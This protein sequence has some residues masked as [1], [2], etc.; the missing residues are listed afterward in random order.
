VGQTNA[1]NRRAFQG[2]IEKK[3]KIRSAKGDSW[4]KNTTLW[5]AAFATLSSGLLRAQDIAVDWQGEAGRYRYVLHVT[6]PG[7]GGG[8]PTL[9]MIDQHLDWEGALPVTS[10]SLESSKLKFSTED[11]DAS[12][13]G[14]VSA[15]GTSIA[16]TWR[17]GPPQ[18]LQFVRAT[19]ETEWRDESPH[20]VQF[21]NV[22]HLVKLE[23]LDWGGSGRPLV[24]L[25]GL[26]NT[27][28]I[29]D[30]FAPK[31]TATYHVYGITRRGFGESS[32]PR[33]GYMADRL[34]DDCAGGH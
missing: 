23:V 9:T 12:Y 5:I 30:Q 17:Q 18:K 21:I 6:K 33:S 1:V 13:E 10:L 8:N 27:A 20:S 28:H 34:G 7:S 29:F 11:P 14:E 2:T 4:M 22:D 19:N 15:D 26:G 31:L 16:G 3:R 25:S 32:H 24:L